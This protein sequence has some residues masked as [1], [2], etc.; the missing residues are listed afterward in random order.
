MLTLSNVMLFL[1]EKGPGRTEK[2]LAE[3]VFGGRA[4]Q[5]LVNQD[6]RLL[7]ER[8]LVERRGAGG[9]SDP[10]RYYLPSPA[11]N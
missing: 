11:A 3:A 10:F 1:I 2:E 6:C 7:A 4:S 9:V 8:A 5:P